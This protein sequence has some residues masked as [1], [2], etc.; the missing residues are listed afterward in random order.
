MEL[1][2][3]ISIVLA[4]MSFVVT[5]AKG[6][7]Q[8]QSVPKALVLY[9]SQLGSTRTLAQ[10]I[11]QQI[12]VNMVEI[13]PKNP[14]PEDFQQTIDRCKREQTTGVLP[15]LEPL[16]VDFNDYEVIFL[17]FPIWFG[18]Y[19]RP[20]A[21]LLRDYDL[22]NKK[23]VVF[24]TFGSGGITESVA[25]MKRRGFN[26]VASGGVRT[27]LLDRG[28]AEMD[29]ILAETQ[30]VRGIVPSLPPYSNKEPV[31]EL[32]RAIFN[33][34]VAGYKMLNASPKTCE[35][36]ERANGIDYRYE[37]SNAA[38]DGTEEDI[39]V[40]VSQDGGPEGKPV[41]TLVDHPQNK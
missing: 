38:P 28:P 37:A 9:Y 20:I 34:A 13:K 14:Y 39:V 10:Y 7:I 24:S 4:I 8:Q 32:T 5:L 15:E 29:R 19:A 11:A 31:N 21:T 40:Y 12:G 16:D 23:I 17:G 3:I 25:H 33:M 22:S 35:Y 6:N 41:F 2:L 1:K 36:R 26:V 30:L 18:T 27:A